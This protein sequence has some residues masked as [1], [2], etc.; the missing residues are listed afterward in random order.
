[1]FEDAYYATQ[2]A[3]AAGCTVLAIEDQTAFR[4]KEA[5]LKI[6]DK[7]VRSFDEMIEED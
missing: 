7:Y 6:A 5:I 2:G 4:E 1:M 3:K